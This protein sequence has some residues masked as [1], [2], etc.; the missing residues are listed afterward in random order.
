VAWCLSA[1]GEHEKARALITDRVKDVAAADHDIAFWLA[2][3]YAMEGMADEAIAWVETAVRLGNENYPHYAASR[4]LDSLRGDPRFQAL[5]D[6]L[7]R[8]V[9]GAAAAGGAD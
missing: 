7:K 2:S 1:Q 3:F 9:G 8:Q 6:D 5:I 4:K